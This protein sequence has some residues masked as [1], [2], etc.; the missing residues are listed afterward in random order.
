MFVLAA[1]GLCAS[2]APQVTYASASSGEPS[3]NALIAWPGWGVQQNLRS[4]SG[5]VSQFQVWVSAEPGRGVATIWASLVDASTDEVLRQVTVEVTPAY[6]PALRTL[7]F[8]SYRV[9]VGQQIALLLQVATFETRYVAFGLA[10]PRSE[11]A[12]VSLNGAADASIGPLAFAHILT[13]NGLRAAILGEQSGRIRLILAGICGVL[14]TLA[15]PR[16]APRLGKFRRAVQRRGTR[17]VHWAL[18]I[19]KLDVGPGVTHSPRI[20]ARVLSMPWYPFLAATVPI[21]H[22]MAINHLHFDVREAAVPLVAALTLASACMAILWPF[23][24]DWN[25]TAAATTVVAVLFFAYGHIDRALDGRVDDRILIALLVVGGV[26][27]IAQ[28][29]RAGRV[30]ASWT[31]FLNLTAAILLVFPAV[32]LLSQAAASLG[33]PS[34]SE[35]VSTNDLI[36]HLPLSKLPAVS[37]TLPDI[38][39]IIL[40]SYGRHDALGNFD[41]A[42]FIAELEKRDF[43]VASEATSNYKFSIQ[44]ITSSLNLEYLN[45][46]GDRTPS[47]EYDLLDAARRNALAAVLKNFGY[48]YVHLESGA[49]VSDKAPLADITFTFTP[50]GVRMGSDED[51]P[52]S[53]LLSRRFILALLETTVLGAIIPQRFLLE[54]DAPLSW[55]SPQRTLQMFDVLT[56]PIRVSGP[57]FVFAHIVKPHR[58]ATFD[59]HGN[60]VSGATMEGLGVQAHDEFGPSHDPSVADAFIGQLI[61]INSLVLKAIDGILENSDDDPI[62]VIAADHGRDEGFPRH[63]ILAAFH[64]PDN[65]DID[66]YPSI[67]SVNHFRYVLD[68]YFD[69]G[70]D[71]IEDVSIEHD[72]EQYDFRDSS[73]NSR[74]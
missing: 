72:G 66:L 2:L 18:G 27:T 11:Y 9:P 30:V 51:T 56:K 70:I 20:V 47:T 61:Y 40:D 8:P 45:S 17:P 38:Y 43:Y 54:D 58:P 44:S 50:A 19:N 52:P 16:V 15:H 5:D 24:A 34:V 62:I 35:A 36:S 41:N 42:D 21:L 49:L 29:V 13:G 7:T 69:L 6:A 25:R 22:F 28:V 39:Y 32:S 26:S 3:G 71:L 1:L 37:R 57:K 67:S 68:Q 23:V 4:L 65:G 10:H 74:K 48:T 73:E 55:Y 53:L 60:Y 46:L 31:P 12:N 63:A 33:R 64:L 59:Q 14:A